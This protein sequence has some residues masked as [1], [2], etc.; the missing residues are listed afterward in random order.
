MTSTTSSLDDSPGTAPAPA[1]RPDRRWALVALAAAVLGFYGAATLVYERLQLF[2]DAGHRTSCDINSWLSC[3]TVMRTPQAEAFGFPNPFIGI[4]AYAVVAVIA[5]AVLAG[6]RFAAWYWWCVQIGVTLGW[7]F[8]LWLWWQTT[9]EIN[10]LCLYCMLVWVVQT[11]LFAHTTARNLEAGVLPAPAAL[12][13]AGGAWAWFA[14]AVLLVLVFG[15]VFVRFA[16]VIL[17][18]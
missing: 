1:V 15:T 13:R 4:V 18:A 12:R 9:F 11:V 10:A 7:A 5:A 17:P 3:G 6:A 16:G 8:V 14:S 2:L